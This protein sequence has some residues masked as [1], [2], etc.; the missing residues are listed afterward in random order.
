[1]WVRPTLFLLITSNSQYL[2][3]CPKDSTHVAA[4][5]TQIVTQRHIRH[6]RASDYLSYRRCTLAHFSAATECRR[7]VRASTSHPTEG[8]MTHIFQLPQKAKGTEN[9]WMDSAPA[10]QWLHQ[11]R[12]WLYIAQYTDDLM[13]HVGLCG[14]TSKR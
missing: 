7:I 5:S 2:D 11:L 14:F 8:V 13:G 10:V 3:K 6:K 1:M 12:T 4:P 9:N